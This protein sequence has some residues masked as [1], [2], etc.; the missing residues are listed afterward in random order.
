[1]SKATFPSLLLVALALLACDRQVDTAFQ[2]DSLLRIRGSVTIP[3]ELGLAELVPAIAFEA[4]L[5]ENVQPC[6]NAAITYDHQRILDVGVRG[7]FPS[8]FTLDVF[9]PP[10]DDAI[11]A[12]TPGEPAFA[13]GYLSAMAVDHPEAITDR[14]PNPQALQE[15][16]DYELQQCGEA[17]GCRVLHSCTLDGQM[18][19]RRTLQC[20][21]E[22]GLVFTNNDCEIAST[23]GDESL[24][25][26][27][28]S[29]DYRVVYFSEPI[30]ADTLLAAA[31]ANGEAISEGYHLYQRVQLRALGTEGPNVRPC[32][33]EAQAQ[34]TETYNAEH[35]T[36]LTEADFSDPTQREA[37][38]DWQRAILR[39][40]REL[41]CPLEGDNPSF[42][43]D[44]IGDELL[45]IELG[46]I[47]PSSIW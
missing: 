14:A 47:D 23:V 43:I 39:A 10:P 21:T 42:R 29:V 33:Q 37:Y 3:Q 4:V 6:C 30:A 19:L 15:W 1:M 45:S 26:A 12:V 8:S 35:G 44:E 40:M 11:Q 41:D 17:A 25:A 20:P 38:Y 31:W 16:H 5:P 18:C 34:A 27:G 46:A 13:V 9:D 2:G 28:Y 32:A 24:A 22:P 36:N 7:E